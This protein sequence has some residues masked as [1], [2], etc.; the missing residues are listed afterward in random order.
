MAENRRRVAVLGGNRLPFARSDTFGFRCAKYSSPVTPA[1]R[2][3]FTAMRRDYSREK[4]VS[5]EV[6][7]AYLSLYAYDRTGLDGEET[8]I[9]DVALT[10]VVVP[11]NPGKNITV[12]SE[13][14]AMRH[15]LRFSG[16]DSAREFNDRLIEQM[17]K[18]KQIRGYLEEDYE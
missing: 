4:P 7:R 17:Q 8:K 3:A 6:Y 1:L 16:V 12:I 18:Q 2:A 5:E 14:V 13:I 9:L 11:L 15:L 10:K